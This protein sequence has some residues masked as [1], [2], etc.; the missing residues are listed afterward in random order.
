MRSLGV[1]ACLQKEWQLFRPCCDVREG[2]REVL[3]A[4]DA[5]V[6][7][8]LTVTVRN[9][10]GS[11]WAGGGRPGKRQQTQIFIL[12]RL[13]RGELEGRMGCPRGFPVFI[14]KEGRA[15]RCS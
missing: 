4:G 7:A 3:W 12:R 13:C 9:H 6:T 10:G 5:E 8:G 15:P 2:L 11:G 1:T 14:S